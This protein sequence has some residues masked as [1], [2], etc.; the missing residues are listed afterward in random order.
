MKITIISDTHNK[1]NELDQFLTEE[2][3]VIIH[4]GD[5]S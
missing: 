2:S 3:D 5:F 1:H 4:C